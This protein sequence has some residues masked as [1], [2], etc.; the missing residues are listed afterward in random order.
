MFNITVLVLLPHYDA[1][2]PMRDGRLLCF[3][4]HGAQRPCVLLRISVFSLGKKPKLIEGLRWKDKR[5]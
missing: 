2:F 1:P 4:C 5:K 3:Y